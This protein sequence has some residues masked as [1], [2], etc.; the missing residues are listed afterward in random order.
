MKL[1]SREFLSF[2]NNQAR[3]LL[4][5]LL[6]FFSLP[7]ALQAGELDGLVLTPG[8]PVQGTVYRRNGSSVSQ[9]TNGAEANDYVQ[10]TNPDTFPFLPSG[11]A[12]AIYT[13]QPDQF[14]RFYTEGTSSTAF[15]SFVARARD[16]RGLTPAQ[17]RDRLAL[18]F[19]PDHQVIVKVPAGSC[20]LN[21]MGGPILGN[22]PGVPGPDG[23]PPGPW[24]S[25]GIEQEYTIGT[26]PNLNCQGAQFLPSSSY[27]N[28][29]PIQA[30]FLWYAPVVEGRNA[31]A[32]ASYLDHL[33]AP[34]PFGDLDGIYNTL[35]LM[36]FGDP[37]LTDA[38]N[39]LSGEA[40]TGLQSVA[41]FNGEQFTNLLLRRLRKQ[42]GSDFQ[43]GAPGEKAPRWS[44]WIYG[45]GSFGSVR[46]DGDRSGY[47]F[48]LGGF[49][50]GIDF[51][52]QPELIVGIN[53]GYSHGDMSFRSDDG[54][55]GSGRVGVY[56]SY[57]PAP[58]RITALLDYAYNQFDVTRSIAFLSRRAKGS[59]HGN[60][61]DTAVEGGYTIRFGKIELEP[62]AG[63]A[64]TT[65]Q[66]SSFSEHDAGDV[67]LD[68]QD[69]RLNSLRSGLGARA[70]FGFDLS[71]FRIIPEVYSLWSHDFLH[72][73]PQ[74]TARFAGAP[75][76]STF[77]VYGARPSADYALV[78]AG[79]SAAVGD[80][81]SFFANYDGDIRSGLNAHSV[82][83]GVR[84]QW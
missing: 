19:L 18:P 16:L 37:P 79:I 28:I 67:N 72:E 31:R 53:A 49:D 22:F 1:Q 9:V 51:K 63:L 74:I 17:V 55:L 70:S 58:W 34:T 78:G 6:W 14:V 21:A 57:A 47:T 42:A 39:D 81:L 52:I 43:T 59:Y 3:W 50:A 10:K 27:V 76:G 36:N 83:A 69:A 13:T 25:G 73:N 77:V 84:L 12:V 24:G 8:I 29:Q 11:P 68:V 45:R 62:L 23:Y 4:L 44:P 38:M 82:T 20:V 54:D 71:G 80:R 60:E 30:N 66:T 35:D 56:G 2:K 65:V 33:P 41:K 40:Y 64:F 61:V 26:T 5:L 15:G 32:V 7:G 46:R 75:S 48:D